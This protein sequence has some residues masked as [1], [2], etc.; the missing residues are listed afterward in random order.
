VVCDLGVIEYQ[1]RAGGAS[2]ES[3]QPS[4][5]CLIHEAQRPNQPV[6]FEPVDAFEAEMAYFV[7][8]VER[9]TPP[10]FVTPADAR[11]ALLTALASRASLESGEIVDLSDIDV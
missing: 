6:I 9:G 1:F 7:A 11:L 3:G 4:H 5:Y 8:C 2:F 10:E